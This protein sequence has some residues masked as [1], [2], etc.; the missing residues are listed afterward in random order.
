MASTF[1]IE[2]ECGHSYRRSITLAEDSAIIANA[3]L[4]DTIIDIMDELHRQEH[5]EFY[6]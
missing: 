1:Y 6:A 2:Y 4:A 5:P 3:P